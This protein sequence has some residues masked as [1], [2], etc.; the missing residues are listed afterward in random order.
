MAFYQLRYSQKI[1]AS[2]AEVWD[3][4]ATPRNLK[5]LLRHT[6]VSIY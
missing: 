6:W 2:V 1:P 3:F 5:K 4:I